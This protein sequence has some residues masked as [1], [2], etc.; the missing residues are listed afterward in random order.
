MKYWAIVVIGLLALFNQVCQADGKKIPLPVLAMDYPPYTDSDADDHG[1]VF[2]VLDEKLRDSPFSATALF[3]PP[4]R[5]SHQINI[6]NWCTSFYPPNSDATGFT[7]YPL[8]EHSIKI[9]LYRRAQDTPFHWKRY[10]E[11]APATVSNTSRAKGLYKDALELKQAGL[12]LVTVNSI[13][14]SFDLLQ[15]GRVD[16]VYSA[17]KTGETVIQEMGF[18][19]ENFE[20]SDT[21]ISEFTIQLWLNK[22]CDTAKQL[23]EFFDSAPSAD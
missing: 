11:L 7:V 19:L 1:I 20:F 21:L 16:Y 9:G 22:Q 6:G 15:R 23:I 5:I 13:Y 8:K 14:Q 4:G 17:Q 2:R 10:E 18:R 12:Q 3:L